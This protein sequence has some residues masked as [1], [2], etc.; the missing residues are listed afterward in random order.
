VIVRPARWPIDES[1]CLH[2]DLSLSDDDAAELINRVQRT[3]GTSFEGFEFRSHFPDETEGIF[4]HVAKLFGFPSKKKRLSVGH[5][6]SVIRAGRWF[7][8]T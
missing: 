5:L 4:Y 1:T 3:F 2:H 7:E 6:L 8:E